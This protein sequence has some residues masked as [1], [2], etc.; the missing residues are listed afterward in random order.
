MI[1]IYNSKTKRQVQAVGKAR[2]EG[3]VA[4]RTGET[5]VACRYDMYSFLRQNWIE[6]FEAER[7]RIQYLAELRRK[8]ES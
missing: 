7:D 2:A 8:G 3:R 1:K 5:Y 6:A 4:A